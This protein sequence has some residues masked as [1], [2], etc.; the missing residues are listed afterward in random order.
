M[1]YPSYSVDKSADN[2]YLSIVFNG[3]G[4]FNENELP[5]VYNV[6]KTLPLLS[7]CSD[8]Y[9]SIVRF[10]IPLDAVP[11]MIMPVLP[12]SLLTNTT[13]MIIGIHNIINQSQNIIYIPDNNEI[14]PNQND[15]KIQI[16]TPYYYVYSYENLIN[17]INIALNTAFLASG[18]GAGVITAGPPF[19]FYNAQTQLIS[20][21]I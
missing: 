15:P 17:S 5:A 19:F 4:F 12:N 16:I 6:T 9:C 14:Q 20:L 2:Y 7:K 8:Y 10:T 1:S 18:F 11:I 3:N 13:P 21:V